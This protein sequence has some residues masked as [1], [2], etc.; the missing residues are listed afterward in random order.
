MTT[1]IPYGRQSIDKTDIDAVIRALKSGWLTQGTEVKK[2]EAALCTATGAKY[3][4]A[5]ANGT[6][7]LHIAYLAAN[8]KKG[9]EVITTANTFAATSNML[10]AVGAKPIFCDIREDTYNIDETKIETLITTRT[11]AIIPVHFAGYPCEMTSLKRIAKKHGLMI[12]EDGAHAIGAQYKNKPIGSIGDM[13]TFSFHPV[14]PITTGEGG[15]VTTNSKH[16]YK[17]LLLFRNHGIQRDKNNQNAIVA[18]GFNY[19]I[20]ELQCALGTS[21]LQKLPTFQKK[22]LEIANRYFKEL[23]GLPGITL[24]KYGTGST[25]AWHLFVIRTKKRDALFTYLHSVNIGAQIHYPVVFKHPYYATSNVSRHMD[26]NVAEAY[27]RTCLS[28]PIYPDLTVREQQL[29]IRAIRSFFKNP[30]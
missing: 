18:L 22:R 2:F 3:A 11:K 15:A 21:Q 14:K 30:Q 26:C 24:P 10:L 12:I 17:R 23:A 16:L 25:H 4:V 20:T 19:R 28:L 13:T 5:V 9:D 6:A 1:H 27:A 8:L 7:A 29:V